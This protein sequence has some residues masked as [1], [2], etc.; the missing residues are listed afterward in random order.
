[1]QRHWRT[2]APPLN[3]TLAAHVGFRPKTSTPTAAD[4]FDLD[5]FLHVAAMFQA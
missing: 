5:A 4:A 3:V 2:V 1:M